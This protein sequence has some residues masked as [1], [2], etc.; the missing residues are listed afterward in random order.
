MS[1]GATQKRDYRQGVTDS[2]IK[3]LEAGTSPWQK[4]WTAGALEMPYNPITG[5]PYR[6]GNAVHLLA[7]GKAAG[8]DDPRWM[9]Y[10]QAQQRGWQVKKGEKGSQIEY[11]EFPDRPTAKQSREKNATRCS[12]ST[13][14]A[15]DDDSPRL[16]HRIYTVFNARQIDGIPEH[17]KKSPQ[18][19][20]ILQAG[21]SILGNSGAR[22][23]H[24]QRD[25]AFYDRRDDSIHLPSK[26]IFHSAGDYY[27]T[28]LHEL[29]HWSGHASRLNRNTLNESRGF[30]DESYAREELRAELTSVFL[31]AERGI[32]HDP[33]NHA[34][35]VGAW[36]KALRDDKN[37][38]FKAA[39]DAHRAADFLLALERE[40]SI[41]KALQAG[42]SPQHRRETS[43]YVAEFEP[44]SG[45]VNIEK[46]ATAREQRTPAD[47]DLSS[48]DSLA[49][50]KRVTE[51]ILDNQVGP[52]RPEAQD[53]KKSFADAQE[54]TRSNLGTNAKTYAA[55]MDSG[56]YCGDIIGE[57]DLHVVQRLNAKSAV[58]HLKHILGGV[59]E[60]GQQVLITYSHSNARI[61]NVP[62]RSR[63]KEL[64]R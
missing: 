59:P 41:E 9:T 29:A 33:A 12:E 58:A 32:P 62:A 1:A 47:N 16:V 63:E 35:Y 24:D 38:I 42:Q 7:A 44:A 45:T 22:I 26:T 23:E 34:A 15:K 52:S 21:E 54:I 61:Q 13:G 10:R 17:S 50:P 43:E 25:R 4:P 2:I 53:L 46:K 64:A 18:E 56:V 30:G 28:A 48:T 3:M 39:K 51:Q 6:G 11:W 57:T 31:A 55:Q 49:E 36:I 5:K 37:E 27:G 19:F 60:T 40:Q 8:S 14:A 20:E